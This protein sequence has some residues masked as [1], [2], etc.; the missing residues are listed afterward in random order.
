MTWA[1]MTIIMEDPMTMAFAIMT[2]NMT[3][4]F[5]TNPYAL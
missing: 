4:A 1:I 2:K 3:N 5:A